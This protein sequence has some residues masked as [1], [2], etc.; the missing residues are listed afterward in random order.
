MANL[1]A[2]ELTAK[3]EK[4]LK[5][6]PVEIQKRMA[7]ALLQLT[8]DPRPDGVKKLTGLQS[9]Y[10]IRVGDYRIVYEVVDREVRVIVIAIG[11]RREIYRK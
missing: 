3:A 4:V 6:L 7:N 9:I 1:Y 5:Q 10:R 8:H 11:H 2:V